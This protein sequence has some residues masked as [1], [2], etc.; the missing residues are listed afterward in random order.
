MCHVAVVGCKKCFP[1]AGS[2]L[3]AAVFIAKPKI[4]LNRGS[5]ALT[6]IPLS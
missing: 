2:Y 1:I 5:L 4:S 6:L 3:N